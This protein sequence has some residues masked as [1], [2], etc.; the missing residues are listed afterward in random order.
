MTHDELIAAADGESEKSPGLV[1]VDITQDQANVIREAWR[2]YRP[3]IEI[4]KEVNTLPGGRIKDID[5]LEAVAT[6]Q[7]GLAGSSLLIK[8]MDAA[9]PALFAASRIMKDYPARQEIRRAGG[10]DPQPFAS[11]MSWSDARIDYLMR[12]YPDYVAPE[13]IVSDVN[14]LPG[15]PLSR[16]KISKFA[17]NI[18]GIRRPP[19]IKTKSA[20]M[21]STG[22]AE[23]SKS[24]RRASSGGPV[25]RPP[26][27]S[28][29]HPPAKAMETVQ[30]APPV[31]V[32]KSASE[33]PF[34]MAAM[35]GPH[36]FADRYREQVRMSGD[37]GVGVAYGVPLDG[38]LSRS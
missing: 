1:L 21:I 8:Q 6:I 17:I 2:T 18:L 19:D 30:P 4:V 32:K 5:E 31:P 20:R 26:P 13:K 22:S 10:K 38:R 3:R 25:F 11:E 37:R 15:L 33:G 7:L 23:P 28:I 36:P 14:A 29:F 34:T 12:W 24:A 35:K 9:R 27:R 16:E